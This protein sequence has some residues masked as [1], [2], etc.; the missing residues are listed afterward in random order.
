VE[1]QDAVGAEEEEK[2]VCNGRIHFIHLSPHELVRGRRRVNVGVSF[3]G[4]GDI[5]IDS[6]EAAVILLFSP[7]DHPNKMQFEGESNI[8]H[9][10]GLLPI[11]F[12]RYAN[13]PCRNEKGVYHS[14]AYIRAEFEAGTEPPVGSAE[15]SGPSRSNPCL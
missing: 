2:T 9:F 14:L 8:K 12:D 11:S 4:V 6:G 10:A 3:K 1:A 13:G 5:G 7:K 15:G